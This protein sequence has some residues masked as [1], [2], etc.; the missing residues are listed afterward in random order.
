MIGIINFIF[1]TEKLL[2][3]LIVFYVTLVGYYSDFYFMVKMTEALT[4]Y[5]FVCFLNLMPKCI[6][7][8]KYILFLEIS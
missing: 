1:I 7:K 8:S 6:F 3:I 4:S 5:F 2:S